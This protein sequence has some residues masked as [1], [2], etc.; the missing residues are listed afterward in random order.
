MLYH[1]MGEPIPARLVRG[2]HGLDV[3][4]AM[5]ERGD[6]CALHEVIRRDE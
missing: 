4:R 2:A 6:T 1:L 5:L 3:R